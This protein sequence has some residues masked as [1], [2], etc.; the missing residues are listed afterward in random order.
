ML[1]GSAEQ[2]PGF[3]ASSNSRL[4]WLKDGKHTAEGPRGERPKAL[5]NFVDGLMGNCKLDLNELWLND[6]Q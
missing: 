1:C 6:E 2:K 4:T 5:A 3:E